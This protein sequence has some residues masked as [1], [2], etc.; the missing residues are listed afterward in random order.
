MTR[1]LNPL[2]VERLHRYWEG[3]EDDI[4]KLFTLLDGWIYILGPGP[5]IPNCDNCRQ[6]LDL[7]WKTCPSCHNITAI[8]YNCNECY[9]CETSNQ[10]PG[11]CQCGDSCGAYI[12]RFCKQDY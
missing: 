4:E 5:E 8:C 10:S 11:C 6:E 12:C 1:Y 2:V 3:N 9:H 7:Y